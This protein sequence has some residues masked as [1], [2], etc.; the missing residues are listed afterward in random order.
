VPVNCE[1]IISSGWSYVVGADWR[2]PEGNK[3]ICGPGELSVVQVAYPDAV[4]YA[5]WAANDCPPRPNGIRRH[6]RF[7][8]RTYPWGMNQARGKGSLRIPGK[9]NSRSRTRR[10]W[11]PGPRPGEIVSAQR[12]P[13]FTTWLEC[14]AMDQRLVSR[15]LLKQL[16]E[17][18]ES[19]ATRQV[20]PPPSIPPNRRK[21]NVCT[22]AA[23]SCT[24][25][26]AAVTWSA[27]RGKGEET[28]SCNHVGFRCV[29]AP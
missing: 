6:V 12:V 27:T 9:D 3:A 2:H 25:S 28:T 11:L 7:S 24:S 16:A 13:A 4:A 8:G 19:R 17:A 15:R 18:V 20:P 1:P 5:K 21:R 14:L 23:H 22:K 29:Q 10:G 26:I